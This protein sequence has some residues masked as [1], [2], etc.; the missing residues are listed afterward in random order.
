MIVRDC[1]TYFILA[2]ERFTTFKLLV[3]AC[4]L[5]RHGTQYL[6]MCRRRP[7][8]NP[9]GGCGTVASGVMLRTH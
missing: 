5:S 8:G 4:L 7:G 9:P 2:Y 3:V 1:S 6:T